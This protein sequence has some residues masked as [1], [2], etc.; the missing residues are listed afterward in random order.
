MINSS[1]PTTLA[2][3]ILSNVVYVPILRASGMPNKRWR[4][5]GLGQ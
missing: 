4:N 5:L 1:I 2:G 3:C